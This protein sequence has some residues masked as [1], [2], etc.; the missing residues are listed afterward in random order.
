MRVIAAFLLG[1]VVT[2]GG[3]YYHD[4]A[5]AKSNTREAQLVNWDLALGLTRSAMEEAGAQIG[6]LFSR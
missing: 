3:A 5:L 2:V 6:R 4:T 1:I